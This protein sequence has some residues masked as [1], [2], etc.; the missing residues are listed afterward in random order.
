MI[1][2]KLKNIKADILEM[3]KLAKKSIE[4]CIDGLRGDVK[5]KKECVKLEQMADVLNTD[6]DYSCVTAI[7]LYQPVARDLRFL[8]G[9]MRISSNYERMT[10][11]AQEIALYD[12]LDDCLLPIFERMKDTLLKMFKVIENGYEGKIDDLRENL[13]RLDDQVDQYYVEAM[14]YISGL[15]R[16]QIDWVLTARHLERIGDLLG[17]VGARII[18]IEVG[19][20]VWIK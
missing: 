2:E 6:I 8:I 14:E 1:E 15:P 12:C 17:K 13:L 3:H 18:F 7:A 11:L 16:C 9:M 20:R 5:K 10:D 19:R 4:L